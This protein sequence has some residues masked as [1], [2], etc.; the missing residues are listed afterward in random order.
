MPALHGI[1]LYDLNDELVATE[2]SGTLE[3]GRSEQAFETALTLGASGAS[4]LTV[5]G[6]YYGV[7]TGEDGAPVR[8]EIVECVRADGDPLLVGRIELPTRSDK[9]T[10]ADSPA[11]I[12]VQYTNY[13]ATQFDRSTWGA[14]LQT[15]FGGLT[16]SPGPT[17]Q[18]NAGQQSIGASQIL[19]AVD[20][21]PADIYLCWAHASIS[22]GV[23]I[24][25]NF[26]MFD[27]GPRPVW[28][29]S[30]NGSAWVLAGSDPA[31]PYTWDRSALPFNVV[32]TPDSGHSSLT[33]SVVITDL[34]D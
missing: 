15:G 33:V 2:R 19:S 13:S 28:Y 12:L 27:I 20:E 10:A 26:Q 7:G 6:R 16:S 3:Q 4:A 21:G 18:A 11:D 5:G 23:W 8:T 32:A 31:Y 30:T 24:H 17:L 34:S 25:F 1:S 9:A 22:F 14:N 29:V